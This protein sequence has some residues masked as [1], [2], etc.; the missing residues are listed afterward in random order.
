MAL[1]ES[2]LQLSYCGGHIISNYFGSEGTVDILISKMVYFKDIR[3]QIKRDEWSYCLG[4]EKT[5]PPTS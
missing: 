5:H 3:L 1:K 4:M 2:S